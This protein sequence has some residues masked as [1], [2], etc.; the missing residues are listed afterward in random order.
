MLLIGGEDHKAGQVADQADRW[1]RLEAWARERF[2]A[3]DSV[4]YQWSGMVMETIDGLAFIGR[5]PMDKD[6]VY[7]VTGDSGMGLTHGTIAGMLLTDLICDRENPWSGIYDPTRKPIWGMAWKEFISETRCT[8]RCNGNSSALSVVRSNEAHSRWD[9]RCRR[10]WAAPSR[11]P[12]G[13]VAGRPT[14]E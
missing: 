14:P 8:S 6:N 13:E 12:S 9:N 2:A 1:D 7:I 11:K 10:L 3:M 5:N 4:E